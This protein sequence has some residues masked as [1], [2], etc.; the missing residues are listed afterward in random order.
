MKKN[1]TKNLIPQESIQSKIF[2]FREKKV[3]FDGDL[4]LLYGVSTKRLNEQVKRNLKRF[5]EDFMFQLR[6]DEADS[7][8]SQI[9]TLKRGQHKKYLSY[10]FTENGVAMLSSVL[11]SET[12]ININIQIMR[13]FAAM[14]EMFDDFR[15]NKEM[16]DKMKKDYNERFILYNRI[17]NAHSKDIKTIYKL[18]APEEETKKGEIGFKVSRRK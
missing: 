13:A 9:A 8:R 3:M 15:K 1:I 5:P 11:N 18:L 14:R 4:A 16:I 10:V 7:L 17:I 2:V 6:K 12:A